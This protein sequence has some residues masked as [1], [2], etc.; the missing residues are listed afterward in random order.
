MSDYGDFSTLQD[1]L[2]MEPGDK[3]IHL[4]MGVCIPS[5]KHMDELSALL[6]QRLAET[7]NKLCKDSAT[8]AANPPES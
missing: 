4:A 1:F 5:K 6:S 3:P 8:P 7:L 2:E